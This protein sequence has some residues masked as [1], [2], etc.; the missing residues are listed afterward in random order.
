MPVAQHNMP[1]TPSGQELCVT[2]HTPASMNKEVPGRKRL[3]WQ[4]GQE[5]V[6]EN[7][8]L[9][10]SQRDT[11]CPQT[12]VRTLRS[13]DLLPGQVGKEPRGMHTPSF[14]DQ[15]PNMNFPTCPAQVA[16]SHCPPQW[17]PHPLSNQGLAR[18]CLT[19]CGY[20]QTR[21]QGWN[22]ELRV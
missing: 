15:T 5:H 4:P 14:L 6:M 2:H 1:L 9:H 19:L 18:G 20:S 3:T 11:R 16:L 12:P 17:A 10:H 21:V 22:P 7:Y 13:Y 8:C